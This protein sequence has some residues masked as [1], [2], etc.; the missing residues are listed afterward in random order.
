MACWWHIFSFTSRL[1]PSL[2]RMIT[3][4]SIFST[5]PTQEERARKKKIIEEQ[6]AK[7]DAQGF[8]DY[9][10]LVKEQIEKRIDLGMNYLSLKNDLMPFL[11]LAKIEDLSTTQILTL[12]KALA[13]RGYILKHNAKGRW[14]E[15]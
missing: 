5:L 15:F 11:P 8:I 13:E 9:C 10:K 12:E 7:I 3:P 14:V 1:S 4:E 2:G 6:N